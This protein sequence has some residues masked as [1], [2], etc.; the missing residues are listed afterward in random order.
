V[1]V[2]TT[3]GYWGITMDNVKIGNTPFLSTPSRAIV[4]TGSS[5]IVFPKE[6][7]LEVAKSYNAIDNNGTFIISKSLYI[8]IFFAMT[9]VFTSCYEKKNRL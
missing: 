4:D 5:L 9:N 2:D 8:H 1:P 3:D 6:L 7:A